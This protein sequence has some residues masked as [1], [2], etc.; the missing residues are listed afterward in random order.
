MQV[1]YS[2][3]ENYFII[4]HCNYYIGGQTTI[5]SF[6]IRLL[7]LREVFLSLIIKHVIVTLSAHFPF[8]KVA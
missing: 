4:I 8:V 3:F 5:S 2:L 7:Q 1:S 6:C